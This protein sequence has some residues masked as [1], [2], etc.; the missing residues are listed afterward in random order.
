[1]PQGGVREGSGRPKGSNNGGG[2]HTYKTEL[3]KKEVLKQ[4]LLNR[5]DLAKS[6]VNKALSGDV[7]ALK[8][9]NERVLGKVT[10]RLEVQGKVNIL[11]LNF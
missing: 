7:P 11:F 1:M 8:E 3:Y 10:D 6:L 4:V 2:N 5:K 9:V